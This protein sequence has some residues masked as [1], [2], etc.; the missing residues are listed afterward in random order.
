MVRLP[1]KKNITI[2]ILNVNEGQPIISSADSFSITENSSQSGSIFKVAATDIDND[3]IRYYLSGSDASAFRL[4]AYSGDL[5]ILSSPDF[6]EKSSYAITF[7]VSESSE[8]TNIFDD[9]QDFKLTIEDVNEAPEI[10]STSTFSLAENISVPALIGQIKVNDPE[11]QSISLTVDS[12]DISI[13]NDGDLYLNVTPNFEIKDLY[14]FSI[15]ASDGVNVSSKDFQLNITDQNDAPRFDALSATYLI[16]EDTEFSYAL[17]ASDEDNDAITY[18]FEGLPNWLSFNDT[19]NKLSGIPLNQSVGTHRITVTA[20]DPSTAHDDLSLKVIVQN[21]NDAPIFDTS[22]LLAVLEE[23]EYSY[24]AVASDVDYADQVSI[25]EIAMPDWLTFDDRS[26]TLVGTPQNHHVGKHAVILAASDISGAITEQSF[27]ITVKN[28]NQAPVITSKEITKAKQSSNYVY[29][30]TFEDPDADE[31]NTIEFKKLPNWLSF[32]QNTRV[33]SG[34]PTQADVG[35]HNVNFV[36]SDLIGESD[37]QNFMVTVADVNDRPNL[38][39]GG[40]VKISENLAI[41]TLIYSATATDLDNDTLTFS[42]KGENAEFFTI[43]GQ[44]GE[45]RT[46]ISPNFETKANYN[47]SVNVTDGLLDDEINLN[48]EILDVNDLPVFA[49]TPNLEILEDSNFKYTFTASDDEDGFVTSYSVLK[50]PSWLNLESLASSARLI[51]TPENDDVGTHDVTLTATDSAGAETQQN[52][53]VVVQNTNDAPYFLDRVAT[54]PAQTFSI[55]SSFEKLMPHM[56]F[57]IA[58]GISVLGSKISE[59]LSEFVQ[60]KEILS[61]TFG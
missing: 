13:T 56:H 52:F 38:T 41:G 16:D 15:E 49:T 33:L 58:G 2:D 9:T 36:V 61:I 50:A 51:G 42:L 28:V 44:T 10:I 7:G 57:T 20:T 4:D 21:T 34:T 43:D 37:E 5:Y 26:N 6:E 39:S 55:T 3:T 17:I 11:G 31:V 48:I 25:N 18:S 14:S 27:E 45:V 54:K 30:I 35:R 47:L 53:S 19:D 12:K 8:I 22:P 59:N 1:L 23:T 24:T 60:G 40:S 29:P 32:N 46:N